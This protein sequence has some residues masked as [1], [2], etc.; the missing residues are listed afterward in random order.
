[1][2]QKQ[3]KPERSG[4]RDLRLNDRHR[5]WGWDCPA[6][7]TDAIFIEYDIGK[8]IAIVEYKHE[9]AQ[10]QSPKH[11]TVKALIDLGDRAG[12][13]VIACRYANDFSWWNIVPLNNIAKAFIPKR[14]EKIS[15]VE[16]V[17]L[18]YTIRNREIP[19]EVTDALSEKDSNA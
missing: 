14:L 11:P 13:P 2:P 17:T 10:P 3:V 16:W 1:M 9:R 15:E 7:D 19:K 8:A 12:V 4:W 5:M 18:L 6:V